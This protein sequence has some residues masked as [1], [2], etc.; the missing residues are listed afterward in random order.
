VFFNHLNLFSNC[1]HVSWCCCLTS[2]FSPINEDNNNHPSTGSRIRQKGNDS[3]HSV[4]AIAWHR[5]AWHTA[6]R[7]IGRTSV[8]PDDKKTN[9]WLRFSA[10]RRVKEQLKYLDPISGRRNRIT[11]RD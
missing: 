11:R 4:P 6:N 8:D 2:G 1:V 10:R 3:K 5:F 9:L 7:E